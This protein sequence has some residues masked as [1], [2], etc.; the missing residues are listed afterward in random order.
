MSAGEFGG[1]L[2]MAQ[3]GLTGLGAALPSSG[4]PAGNRC[5]SVGR[6]CCSAIRELFYRIRDFLRSAFRRFYAESFSDS[7]DV[8]RVAVEALK[9]YLE[10]NPFDDADRDRAGVKIIEKL[11]EELFKEYRNDKPPGY[12]S[13]QTFASGCVF[14]QL[15]EGNLFKLENVLLL[16]D[17]DLIDPN[18]IF[19]EDFGEYS[20]SLYIDE[21]GK[22]DK[23]THLE[24]CQELGDLENFLRG[25]SNNLEKVFPFL[26]KVAQFVASLDLKHVS[27]GRLRNNMRVFY[28]LCAACCGNLSLR[29]FIN[30]H[31]FSQLK[32]DEQLSLK[33]IFSQFPC[34]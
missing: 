18:E 31:I 22:I 28:T 9:E 34:V 15:G 33:P 11:L 19:L 27:L 8:V 16:Y 7:D 17:S 12:L 23:S 10:N 32:R 29:D 24:V 4:V 13:L 2:A 21:Q 30:R 1:L 26:G 5:L 3:V 25:E 14:N 20:Y 6:M